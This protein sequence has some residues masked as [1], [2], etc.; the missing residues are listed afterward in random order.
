MKYFISSSEVAS[1]PRTFKMF[2]FTGFFLFILFLV[3]NKE[4]RDNI[5]K[6]IHGVSLASVFGQSTSNTP[7]W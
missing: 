3:R 5:A 7:Q 4:F 2:I 6:I 1:N